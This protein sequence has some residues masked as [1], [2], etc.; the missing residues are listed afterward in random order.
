MSDTPI[1]TTVAHTARVWNY[2]LGGRDH[3]PADREVGDTIR[4]VMPQIVEAARGNRLFLRRA[5]THLARE[6]GIRQ[7]LDAGSGLPAAD[8][9]H[10]VAQAHAPDARVVYVDNDPMVLT[11][12][13]A[14]LT[15]TPKERIRFVGAD[16]RE[17]DTVLEAARETLDLD[18]PVALTLLGAMGHIADL[19]EALEVVRA[20]V[21]ALAPGSFLALCDGVHTGVEFAADARTVEALRHWHEE[22]AQPYHMRSVADFPRFFEGLEPVD[23]GLVPVT[24]WRPEPVEVGEVRD[25]PQFCGLARKG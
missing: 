9:T 2:W 22:V 12:A 20:Y 10:E 17:T 14:L 18:Q 4:D 8:N 16:L 21:D 24:R 15:G 6:E 1:D 7:F 13:G 5:V 19:D 11:H 25:I 3:Y 23:P